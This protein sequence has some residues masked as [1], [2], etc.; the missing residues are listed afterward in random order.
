V[1]SELILSVVVFVLLMV[2]AI[3]LYRGSARALSEKDRNVSRRLGLNTSTRT[4][5]QA[6]ILTEDDDNPGPASGSYLI[7][8]SLYSLVDQAGIDLSARVLV[9]IVGA[10]FVAGSLLS[11]VF[12]NV[13]GAI[14]VGLAIGLSPLLYLRFKRRARLRQFVEQLPYLL[15]LLRS[16][17]RLD[18]LF[19]ELCS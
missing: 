9:G 12:L 19:C 8:K 6:S 3:L 10:L 4:L 7:P 14:A 16:A 13:D 5:A 11:L 15:D 17:W 1:D 2:T 18:I